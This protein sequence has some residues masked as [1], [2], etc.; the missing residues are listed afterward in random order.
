MGI[1]ML[2]RRTARAQAQHQVP[3]RADTMADLSAPLPPVPPFAAN[4]STGRIPTTRAETLRRSTVAL[5]RRLTHRDG[6]A[7]TDD[8]AGTP[9][10]DTASETPRWRLWT[11][12]GLGC[13]AL[14]LS[15][16]PRPNRPTRS[17]TVF[18]VPPP[19]TAAT[20]GPDDSPRPQ[21]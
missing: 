2:H 20:T 10:P 8:T 15:R 6:T 3:A 17:F 9:G 19:T 16:L 11:E 1:R 12:L 14:L 7:T 13:L 18:V 21:S 5:A 4:A